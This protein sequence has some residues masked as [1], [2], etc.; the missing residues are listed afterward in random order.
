MKIAF[1]IDP[2]PSSEQINAFKWVKKRTG[3]AFQIEIEKINKINLDEFNIIWWHYDKDL[4]LPESVKDEKFKST[5]LNFINRG[6]NLLLTLSAVKLLNEI[7]IEPVEPDFEKFEIINTKTATPKGF[8]S[9]L[10]HPIFRKLQNGVDVFL[11]SHSDKF[12]TIAY[13]DKIPQNLKVV[14]VE[15]NDKEINFR[16][17]IAFEF[18][19]KGWIIAIGGYIYFSEVE[20]PFFVNL[21]RL[22]LN[23]LLY[24]NNP[25]KFPEPRT[26]WSFAEGIEM[27][28]LKLEDKALRTA[29]KKIGKKESKIST[30]IENECIVQGEKIV[31]KISKDAIKSV[32]IPPFQLIDLLTISI[33]NG[34]KFSP[35]ENVQMTFKPESI[36]R[37]FHLNLVKFKETIFTHPKK[38]VLILNYLITSDEDIEIC[39]HIKVAPKTLGSTLIPLK[40]FHFGFD[41]KLKSIY[42]SNDE[43]FSLLLGSARKPESLQFKTEDV[44]TV[45]ICY[46]ISAGLEK[47]FNFAIVGNVKHPRK[48][49]LHLKELYKFALKS[50]HKV[51]KENLKSVKNKLRKQLT[52][53]TPDENLNEKF[54]LALT[55]LTR[56]AK[57]TKTIGRFFVDDPENCKANSETILKILPTLLKIGEYELVRDTLEFLGRYINL[58]GELPSK[59]SLSG[60]FEYND[61]NL[62]WEYIKIC[63]DYLRCS[64][65]KLFAK[66]TWGRLKKLIGESELEK[67]KP[68]VIDSLLLF[69]KVLDDEVWIEKLNELKTTKIKQ[70]D[71]TN[72]EL[73]I[74]FFD[75]NSAFSLSKFILATTFNHLHF[76]VDAFEKKLCFSPLV[77]D[78]WDFLCVRNIRLQNMRIHI[79]MEKGENYVNFTFEKRDLPEVKVIFKP[80]FEKNCKVEKIL[81]DDKPVESFNYEDDKLKVKFSFRFKRWVKIIFNAGIC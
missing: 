5:I 33:K 7:G 20:N 74:E 70:N 46:R 66:F 78:E 12:L 57:D 54:K 50:P 59:I 51:F 76:D 42:I 79:A 41:E 43:L 45:R 80:R 4:N 25:S 27:S 55:T 11:P 56:F 6:G 71:F 17:K 10:G 32:S 60:I 47:A 3:C 1:L 19:D 67:L 24:L 72:Q 28:N 34:A 61:E 37:D 68:D 21:D 22:V 9:F 81:I 44:L 73:K 65:D 14:A 13:L 16:K 53:L 75:V 36:V 58:K 69:A 40:N 64:K 26:Y 30:T 31:A 29:Q 48:D 77:K 35:V 18:K 2:K 63:A 23:S 15:K 8:V 49:I 52:I 62:K 38:P 39:F